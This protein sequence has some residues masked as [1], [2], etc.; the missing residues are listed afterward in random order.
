MPFRAMRSLT[1]TVLSVLTVYAS[2]DGIAS[3]PPPEQIL[4][5]IS[6][7]RELFAAEPSL[8]DL[9]GSFVVVGDIHGNVTDLVRIFERM[10]YPPDAKYVVIGD[11]VDRGPNSVEVMLLLFA[12]K[13]LFKDDIFLVRGNHECDSL[14]R[15]F[16]FKGEC[17][18]KLGSAVYTNFIECFAFLPFAARINGKVLCVHGGIGPEVP[19]LE[20]IE[21]LCRPMRSYDSPVSNALV[22]SD[23]RAEV[24]GFTPSDRGLGSFYNS[25]VLE[26]FL[27]AHG[28]SLLIRGHEFCPDGYDRP[29][30][31]DGKCITVFSSS[32]Y[33]GAGNSAA[34]IRVDPMADPVF[35]VFAPILANSGHR[36]AMIPEWVIASGGD[37]RAPFDE[38]E[39]DLDGPNFLDLVVIDSA[40]LFT[41][42]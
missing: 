20:A 4:E 29:F 12:L 37:S 21:G 10:G 17:E 5:Q 9:H 16:G 27:S 26:H 15:S 1:D 3:L 19:N 18:M 42:F 33:C 36:I 25:E 13:L 41:E 31:V 30:G 32:D 22:W 40:D 11:F 7:C 2:P 24:T 39:S 14:C 8:L 38:L 28:L 6:Q 35:E 34:V 23:P